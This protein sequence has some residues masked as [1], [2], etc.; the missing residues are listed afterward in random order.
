[1]QT[2]KVSVVLLS[3]MAIWPNQSRAMTVEHFDRM[4]PEDQRHYVMFLATEAK[5]LLIQERQPELARNVERVF[6]EFP[7]GDDRSRGE[8]QFEAS[9]AEARVSKI[10]FSLSHTPS[11]EVEFAFV[12]AL[13]RLGIKPSRAFFEK[14]G[15]ATYNRVFFQKELSPKP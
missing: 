5:K 10:Q 13:F 1:M 12:D 8:R 7:S 4:T 14:F 6:R 3:A 9:I 11:G 15:P 2:L